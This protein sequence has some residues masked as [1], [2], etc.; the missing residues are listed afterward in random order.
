MGAGGV[1]AGTSGGG[2]FRSTDDGESWVAVNDGLDHKSVESFLAADGALFVGTQTGGLYRS[3]ND[4][5]SWSAVGT[6]LPILGVQALGIDDS[7]L[8]AG[9]GTTLWMRPLSDFVTSADE[10]SQPPSTWALEQNYPNPFNTATVI[11]YAVAGSKEYAGGSMEITLVVYDLLGREATVLV[12]ERK[13]PG[14]Y[15]VS[16]DA[17]RLASGVYFLRLR[18]RLT[19]GTPGETFIATRKLVLLR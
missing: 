8:Y 3:T 13:A 9:V 6:G 10:M 1:F 14:S 4:G 2:V 19:G 5:T 12:N 18:G 7:N 11:R 17:A 15:N 16:F